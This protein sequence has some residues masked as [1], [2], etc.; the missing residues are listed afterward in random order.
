[1][2]HVWMNHVIYARALSHMNQS[3]HT[4][5]W[6]M[7]HIWMSHVTHMNESCHTYEWVTSHIWMSRVHIWMSHVIRENE[8]CHTYEWVLSHR[9]SVQ[10]FKSIDPSDDSTLRPQGTCDMTHPWLHTCD[11]THSSVQ[12]ESILLKEPYNLTKDHRILPKEP[13]VPPCPL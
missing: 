4:Y 3:C 2:C 9:W 8:S 7:S 12:Y 5:E 6:V 11:M 13:Y 10:S 1:M